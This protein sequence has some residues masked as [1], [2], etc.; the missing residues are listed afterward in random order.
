MNLDK[1]NLK[2][3]GIVSALS[4]QLVT[5]IVVGLVS[6]GWLDGRF[7]TSPLFIII[8]CLLG[9]FIG[10]ITFI[11]GLKLLENK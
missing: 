10:M 1:K 4:V 7:K 2:T 5:N 3:Y 8:G 11:K 6:G 9:L